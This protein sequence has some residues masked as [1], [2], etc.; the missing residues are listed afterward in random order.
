MQTPTCLLYR[1]HFFI[2]PRVALVACALGASFALGDLTAARAAEDGAVSVQTTTESTS[3]RLF[4]DKLSDGGEWFQTD[5]YGYVFQ[6]RVAAEDKTWRPYTDGYWA[7]TEAGWTWVSNEDFGWAVYHYG[8]WAN[9]VDAGWVWVPGADWSPGLVS[10]RV[11]KD[12]KRVGWAPLPPEARVSQGE[13][14]EAWV[15]T[16]YDIGPE[17]YTFIDTEHFGESS[18]RSHVIPIEQN[19]TIITETKN[20]TRINYRTVESRS[21]IY[22]G[23]PDVTVIRESSGRPVRELRLETRTENVEFFERGDRRSIS[24]VNGNRLVMAIAPPEVIA[25][26]SIRVSQP[27]RI[28]RHLTN[29]TVDRGY[30]GIRDPQ[31]AERVRVA[32]RAQSPPPPPQVER[33][34]AAAMRREGAAAPADRNARPG[35]AEGAPGAAR[36][37]ASASPLPGVSPA[38]AQQPTPAN[39]REGR[40]EPGATPAAASARGPAAPPTPSPAATPETGRS[41]QPR[42]NATPEASPE[43]SAARPANTPEASPTPRRG[44]NRENAPQERPGNAAEGSPTPRASEERQ[45][46]AEERG[47]GHRPPQAGEQ[48]REKAEPTPASARN[49]EGGA[50]EER[51]SPPAATPRANEDETEKKPSKSEAAPRA[52]TTPSE[53]SEKTERAPRHEDQSDAREGEGKKS[54][55]PNAEAGASRPA[56][57]EGRSQEKSDGNDKKERAEK[58][59][60]SEPSA[61]EK[62]RSTAKP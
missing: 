26:A 44:A 5:S 22:G 32:L 55:G 1:P 39:D 48:G 21:I 25:S 24:V 18:Y 43:A 20:V 36:A 45:N 8:R 31:Q 9:L 7:Q 33:A 2:P 23:G 12:H 57:G 37:E 53:P 60:A 14:I 52:R 3:Y 27:A 59:E 58:R 11:S 4:Y 42:P 51:K 28:N 41:G 50:R 61:G 35:R 17:A 15:D 16:A 13:A 29:V 34:A 54:S 56:S 6:P 46:R 38:A 30:R 10:W 40:R 19:T 62:P 49:R 47:S